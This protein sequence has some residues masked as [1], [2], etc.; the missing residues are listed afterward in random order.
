MTA[1][2]GL[3]RRAARVTREAFPLA[4]NTL[5]FRTHADSEGVVERQARIGWQEVWSVI[6]A[7]AVRRLGKPL[8]WTYFYLAVF[9]IVAVALCILV[10]RFSW[11]E[12]ECPPTAES[13]SRRAP[14]LGSPRLE[15]H[16]QIGLHAAALLARTA[17]VAAAGGRRHDDDFTAE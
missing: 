1:V 13:C 4:A 15:P 11:L 2:A 3:A 8:L 16:R 12:R 14:R 10:M 17:I 5:R 6:K 9:G 7:S